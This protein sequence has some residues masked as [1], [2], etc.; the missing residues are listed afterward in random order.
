MSQVTLKATK[1]EPGK[2]TAKAIRRNGSVP[3]VYYAKNQDPVHFSVQT[4]DLRPVVYTAEAK[5]I[6]LVVEGAAGK[7]AI[8]KD[9]S[10]DPITDQI[11][12]IDLLGVAAGEKLN[13]DIPLHLTGQAAGV[14]MGGI[15]E[16][17]MHKAHCVVDPTKM[18]EHIDVDVT[19]L[20]VNQSIHISDL[21]IPGVE[22]TDRPDAVIVACV[23]PK[24]GG[25]TADLTQGEPKLVGED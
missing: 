7:S 16:H 6:N 23:P 5:M 15:L 3:G 13:V 10:F 8:L 12:H 25:D 11:L 22:F 4:L 9:I 1:R 2:Q 21:N 18:P 17:V 14:R 24:T 20:G 19:N